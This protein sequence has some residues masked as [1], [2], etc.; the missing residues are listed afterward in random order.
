MPVDVEARVIRNA[1]LSAEYNV[2][3]LAAPEIAAMTQPGQFVMVKPGRRSDPLLRRPF[4]VFE[5][6]RT[7]G[8]IKYRDAFKLGA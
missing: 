1:R 4:S 7:G 8:R 2:I 6:L 5:I 3:A